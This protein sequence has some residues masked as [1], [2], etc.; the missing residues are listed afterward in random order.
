MMNGLR[1][2]AGVPAEFFSARTG[3]DSTS[4]DAQISSLQRQGLM[5][6]SANRY[7]TT[8]LGYQFLNTVLQHF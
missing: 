2:K 1:L 5:E 8:P 3:L 7:S 4:I 6:A